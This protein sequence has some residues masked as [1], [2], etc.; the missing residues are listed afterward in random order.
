MDEIKIY[1]EEIEP[2]QDALETMTDD[3]IENAEYCD[4]TI[5]DLRDACKKLLEQRQEPRP[6]ETIV[7]GTQMAKDFHNWYEEL[8]PEFGYETRDETKELDFDSPNGKLML[9]V[10]ERIIEKYQ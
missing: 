3:W 10:C 9:A 1:T 4:Q 7:T 5:I 8:A 6:H 2:I